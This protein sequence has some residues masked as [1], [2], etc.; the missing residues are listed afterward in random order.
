MRASTLPKRRYSQRLRL[1]QNRVLP[2]LVDYNF[3]YRS[4]ALHNLLFSNYWDI[5]L[6]KSTDAVARIP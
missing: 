4:S 1:S 6:H 5:G 3:A 2:Q